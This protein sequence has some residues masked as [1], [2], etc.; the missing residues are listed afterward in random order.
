MLYAVLKSAVAQG[1][2]RE[3]CCHPHHRGKRTTVCTPPSAICCHPSV[4]A[5][6]NLMQLQAVFRF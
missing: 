6:W 5:L 2:L 4:K 1:L 3:L